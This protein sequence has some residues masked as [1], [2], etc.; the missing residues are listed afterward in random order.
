M[1]LFKNLFSCIYCN[2]LSNYHSHSVSYL[3]ANPLQLINKINVAIKAIFG[4]I[5]RRMFQW[6]SLNDLTQTFMINRKITFSCDDGQQCFEPIFLLSAEKVFQIISASIIHVK[7][8]F[9]NFWIQLDAQLMRNHNYCCTDKKKFRKKWNQP[10]SCCL[11]N[12][13]KPRPKSTANIMSF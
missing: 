2:K 9:C 8:D 3:L 5:H 7:Y 4:Q 12:T 10:R 13:R 6:T 1:Q 11:K